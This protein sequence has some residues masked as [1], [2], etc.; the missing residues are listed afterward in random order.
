MLYLNVTK[1][2]LGAQNSKTSLKRKDENMIN[3]INMVLYFEKDFW[4]IM[5][6]GVSL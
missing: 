2:S 4:L 5:V 6:T 3:A 1:P